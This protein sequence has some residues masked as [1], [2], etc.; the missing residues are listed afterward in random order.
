[1]FFFLRLKKE[2]RLNSRFAFGIEQTVVDVKRTCGAATFLII[3]AA[4]GTF[5]GAGGVGDKF[6]A[7]F[8]FLKGLF[9]HSAGA[10]DF[11]VADSFF[12]DHNYACVAM[13]F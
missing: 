3:D 2:L 9:E 5:A 1:M 8:D 7:C 13:A 11:A 6:L 12:V 10:F 4:C